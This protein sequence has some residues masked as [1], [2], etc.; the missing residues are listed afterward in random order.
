VSN[1]YYILVWDGWSAGLNMINPRLLS[2]G[3][4]AL[5]YPKYWVQFDHTEEEAVELYGLTNYFDWKIV[6]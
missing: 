2:I 3:K 1:G 5:G 6:R 4:D